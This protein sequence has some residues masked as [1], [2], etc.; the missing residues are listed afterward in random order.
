MKENKEIDVIGITKNGE[1][2]KHNDLNKLQKENT[3]QTNT[4]N[5][6]TGGFTTSDKTLKY[7]P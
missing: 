3:Q 1:I 7:N 5:Q 4:N 6:Q 2:I